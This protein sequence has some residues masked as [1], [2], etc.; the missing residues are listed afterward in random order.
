MCGN[1]FLSLVFGL[2]MV[3]LQTDN[4]PLIDIGSIILLDINSNHLQIYI[5]NGRDSLM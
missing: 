4:C 3:L 1:E 5:Y 2:H